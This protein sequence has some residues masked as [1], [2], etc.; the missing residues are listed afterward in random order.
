MYT[1]PNG[2]QCEEIFAQFVYSLDFTPENMKSNNFKTITL[3][4]VYLTR[5][6]SVPSKYPGGRK[7][8]RD[9]SYFYFHIGQHRK[10]CIINIMHTVM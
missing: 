8:R 2:H 4:S 1:K 7:L 5:R 6:K 3:S 9:F 10:M